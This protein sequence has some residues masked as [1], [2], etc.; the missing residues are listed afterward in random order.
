MPPLTLAELEMFLIAGAAAL[1]GGMIRGFV[2]FGGAVTM[3]LILTHFFDPTSV[4][5]RVAI[6]DLIANVRLL[7]T[8]WREVEW[9]TAGIVTVATCVAI[10]LG[11]FALLAIDPV[12][13]KKGIAGI[14]AVCALFLLAGKRVRT[15]ATVAVLI[16]VGLVSGVVMGATYIAL[17]FM[18]FVYALPMQATV[19]RATG[20]QW[21]FFTTLVLIAIFL[22]SGD[23]VWDDLWRAGLVGVVYLG[24]AW[25][26]AHLFRRTDEALFRR[27]VLIF[28]LVLSLIGMLT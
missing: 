11:V 4:V 24:S 15:R 27:I 7:P 6:V 1:V 14:A 18:I 20:I 25:I 21:G 19:S 16:G 2:G 28:L 17:V 5:A 12:T 10:P 3:I 8:T 13:M 23:L 9:R 26:G 22:F